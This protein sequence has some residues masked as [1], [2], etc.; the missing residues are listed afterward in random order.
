MREAIASRFPI[1]DR[2]ISIMLPDDMIIAP[3][4]NKH[5][6]DIY[7]IHRMECPFES[8]CEHWESKPEQ[9][10]QQQAAICLPVF[11]I[12]KSAAISSPTVGAVKKE[13]PDPEQDRQ[14]F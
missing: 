10:A 3:E 12:Y 7:R 9:A 8:D 11:S 14:Q 4:L 2:N 1:V 5:Q 13:E 6:E